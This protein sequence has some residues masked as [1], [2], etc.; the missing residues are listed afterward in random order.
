MNPLSSG[1][2]LSTAPLKCCRLPQKY[3]CVHDFVKTS[4]NTHNNALTVQWKSMGHF[5]NEA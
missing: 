5:M 4:K 1:Y 3:N 2:G